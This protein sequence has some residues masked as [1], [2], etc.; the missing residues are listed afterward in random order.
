MKAEEAR[1]LVDNFI[2]EGLNPESVF[3]SWARKL[4]AQHVAD[5]E[6]AK[7]KDYPY[8][9]DEAAAMHILQFFEYI[10][11]SEG[12]FRGKPFDLHGWQ[13]FTLWCVYGWK[14][15]SNEWR[16]YFK[17]YI[18]IA[19][20]NGK[21]E[22]LSGIG[23][24]GHRF[25]KY[26]RDAQ[27][28]WFATAK[29]QATIGFRKQQAMTRL[30]CAKSPTYSSK[31]R[32][33]THSISD[34]DANGFTSYLGRDSKS[35]DGTNPFYGICDEYHAHPNNDMMDVIE[36]GMG[37]R[38][39][40]LIWVITTA[41][42]NPDGVCAT[43]EKTCKQILDGVIPNPGI[44]PL[45]FDIDQDDDWQDERIWKKANP[46]L[47]VSISYDYLRR[48]LSKALTEGT[49]AKNNFLTKNLNVWVTSLDNWIDDA[50]WM[51]GAEIVTESELIGR[52]CVGGLDLAST[53]D[54]CSLIWLFP[55]ENEGEKI[56]ILFR[57]WVPEDEAIKV[58]KLRG[59][60]YLKWIEAGE[61]TATPG[62]VT[63][64]D[65]ILKQIDDDAQKF[66][67]HS[68]AYDR[69][70]AG[71]VSKRLTDSG[72]TVSPFGQGFLSMSAPTKELERL[73]KGG[74]IQHGGNQVLRWMASNA[75][76]QRD[77]SDNIKVVKDKAFGKVDG[78]VA[79]VMALGQWVTFKDEINTN[80]NVFTIL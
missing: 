68:I 1:K 22:F 54:T 70:G 69:Y 59:F 63:D 50:D 16:R 73:I 52:S 3:S 38:K 24:Y 2:S 58:T 29:K 45:I 42:K 15:K 76:V 79:L 17:V 9:F 4:V 27:V 41:G 26:E 25:D 43:F 5:L 23:I 53:S 12:N 46:S 14:V 10:Q 55:P 20:K 18:K 13:A 77:P 21:T 39:S 7:S 65:Y 56:K 34:R 47:G 32:V 64:Y 78:I 37:A 33:Y 35:E 62:N 8:Y 80:Y 61:L 67:I 31:V 60:P 75:V 57:C 51:Q 72:I 71:Q 74:Q 6:A 48:E 66:K 40:P 19:R 44:F 49:T 11:F 36:S 28:Y 30:L